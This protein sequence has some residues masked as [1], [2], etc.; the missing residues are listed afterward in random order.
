MSPTSPNKV[1]GMLLKTLT[2][3]TIIIAPTR[4]V[5]AVVR[6]WKTVTTESEKI[7]NR[8]GEVDANPM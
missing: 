6:E 4:V 2:C 7:R 8:V 3:I 1:R 5:F